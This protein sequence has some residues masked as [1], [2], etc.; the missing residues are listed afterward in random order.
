M[1]VTPTSLLSLSTTEQNIVTRAET[2]IDADL[3][4]KFVRGK[5]V[6]VRHAVIDF[7]F[8]ENPRVLDAVLDLYT[9]AGWEIARYE[10]D[11]RKWFSFSEA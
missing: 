1:A 7:V 5:S 11:G 9:A 10:K 4:D 8:D 6:S 3:R 2:A